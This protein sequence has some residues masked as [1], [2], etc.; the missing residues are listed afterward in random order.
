MSRRGTRSKRGDLLG[1]IQAEE[2]KA[3]MDYYARSVQ[4]GGLAGDTGE[5][6]LGE[7]RG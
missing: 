7:A 4:Q 6:G 5:G 2:M 1:L 3:D